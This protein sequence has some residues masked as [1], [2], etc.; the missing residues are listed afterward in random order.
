LTYNLAENIIPVKRF[1]IISDWS[2]LFLFIG[3][4]YNW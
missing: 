2:I 1:R 4:F 3:Y